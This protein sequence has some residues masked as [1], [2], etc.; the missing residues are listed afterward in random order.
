[1][2]AAPPNTLMLLF[3]SCTCALPRDVR[4][5]FHQNKHTHISI[6]VH[7]R[8]PVFKVALH[9][10]YGDLRVKSLFR[11]YKQLG[12]PVCSISLRHDAFFGHIKSSSGENDFIISY[13]VT[14][15]LNHMHDHA[16]FVSVLVCV[17]M[18][19]V[20]LL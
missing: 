14:F 9:H 17:S 15:R 5:I 7:S 2:G 8:A 4:V 20:Y 18:L 11:K 13:R 12:F 10:N 3:P 19:T 1:M 16:L 6:K